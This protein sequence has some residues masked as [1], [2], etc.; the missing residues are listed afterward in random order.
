MTDTKPY[1][2]MPSAPHEVL[3]KYEDWEAELIRDDRCWQSG[4]NPKLTSEL[5]DKLI[6]IQGQRNKVLYP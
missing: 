6:E 1:V 5:W 4:S 3:K 2:Q